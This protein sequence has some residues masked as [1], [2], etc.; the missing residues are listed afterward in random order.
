MNTT[1]S[2]T[3]IVY[4]N[5]GSCKVRIEKAAM[6]NGVS[7]ADWNKDNKVLTLIYNPTKVSSDAIL[8]NIASVGHDNEKFKADDKAYNALQGCCQYERKK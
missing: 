5:C 6:L 8:K 1:K 7:K 2:E 4:G 3:F